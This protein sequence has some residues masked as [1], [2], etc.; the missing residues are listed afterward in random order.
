MSEFNE[1]VSGQERVT[2]D[3]VGYSDRIEQGSG[4]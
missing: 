1:M 2:T 4:K 3:E